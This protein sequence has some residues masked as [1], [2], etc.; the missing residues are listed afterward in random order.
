MTLVY[1][2]AQ[3]HS[4]AGLLRN[5]DREGA[6]AFLQP[7]RYRITVRKEGF[8]PL[9]RSGIS[10]EVD[11]AAQFSR[12]SVALAS[13][14][15]WRTGGA[16]QATNITLSSG[17]TSAS[18]RDSKLNLGVRFEPYLPYVDAA[19]RVSVFRPGSGQSQVY[20]NAPEGLLFPGDPGVPRGGTESSVW[21]FA[22]RVGF[23]WAPFGD[24]K[25]SIRSGYGIFF[26]S[27]MMSAI[28]NRFSNS[29]PHGLRLDL[30]PAPGPFDDP[31]AGNNPFPLQSPPP[32]D[33]V[34]PAGLITATYPDRFKTPYLQSWHFTIERELRTNWTVRAAYAGS[35]GT[36]LLQGRQGN[37]AVYIPGRSTRKLRVPPL[38]RGEAT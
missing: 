31:Y 13:E 22:P 26:D 5:R 30:R 7:G 8:R 1:L 6:M 24:T 19:N 14:C 16:T 29:P 11:Q 9:S 35:K 17:T 4:L 27:A 38:P 3:E 21:N 15:V 37:A 23:A 34:F 36:A 25:T 2:L 20:V 32:R 12:P 28:H 33:V 18:R 10:L